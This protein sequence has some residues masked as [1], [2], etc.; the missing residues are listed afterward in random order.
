MFFK[1]YPKLMLLSPVS[2]ISAA[3]LYLIVEVNRFV[4]KRPCG[5]VKPTI[6]DSHTYEW[7]KQNLVPV[8]LFWQFISYR[9]TVRFEKLNTVGF[10]ILH[11]E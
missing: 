8:S 9:W 3:V 4:G 11:A 5:T 6:L 1:D 2:F 10:L 7:N